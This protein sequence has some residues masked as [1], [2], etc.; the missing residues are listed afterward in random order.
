MGENNNNNSTAKTIVIVYA[1]ET[2]QAKII[3]ET[4]NDLAVENGFQPKLYNINQH[5]KEFNFN[6][7]TDP[8]VFICSTTGDG[9]TPETAR[10]CYFKLKRL[11]TET[12]KAYLSNLNY[13]LLGL[14]D[15][16]YTQF[17]NGPKL[18]HK[19]FEQLGAKC[20]YG[21]FWA[22]DGTGLELEVEP[23]KD[24]LWDALDEFYAKKNAPCP[25]I[26]H[27]LCLKTK[28]LIINDV[29]SEIQLT[30]PELVENHLAIEYEPSKDESFS[31]KELDLLKS[32]PHI[33]PQA[34]IGVFKCEVTQNS[35]MTSLDPEKDL[36]DFK[37]KY[38]LKFRLTDSF[39]GNEMKKAEFSY[40][41]GHAIDIVCPNSKDEVNKLLKRLK[42]ESPDQLI[43]IK[44]LDPAKKLG[45]SFVKLTE[46]HSISVEFLFTYCVDLRVNCLKKNFLRM[47]SFYCSDKL[48]Q[49]RLLELCSKEGSE[50]YLEIVKG[51]ALT[52]LD[53]LNTF[54][55][56]HPPLAHLIQ[57]LPLQTARS[58]TL[59]SYLNES[60]DIFKHEMEIV[61][62]MVTFEKNEYRT[63]KRNG[64]GTDYL[65]KIGVKESVYFLKR[66]FHNFTFPTGAESKKPIIMIG[67]GTGLAP[68]I[69]YLRHAKHQFD[70]KINTDPVEKWLFYGCRN[71][72]KDF[73]FKEE[74]FNDFLPFLT[75]F[76][77]AYSKFHLN[78][79]NGYK[80]DWYVSE[81]HHLK[82]SKYVQDII[83]HHSQELVRLINEKEG[84]IYLCGDA[85]N[86]SKD[87]MNCFVECLSKELSITAE[88]ANKY[89]MN[90]IKNKR[91]KQD[92]WA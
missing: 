28:N 27:Q 9:E 14:G 38:N 72:N 36:N 56:C 22:D 87:V 10:K 51:N 40:E 20:F 2:G 88:E 54:D 33:F 76:K 24:G 74:I 89:I 70:A 64:V 75:E 57:M 19:R 29:N 65:S 23:F 44:T 52:L 17:C 58:Y 50:H 15:T 86:M 13:A 43:K 31:S 73:L 45:S 26:E 82:E 61:F 18:F 62:N 39:V 37:Y 55:S 53:I 47:L 69:S 1:S 25:E 67:P 59:C 78:Q 41:P 34:A 77:V 92:I 63:Y 30:L 85:Q 60:D 68:F 16:N 84:Y 8:V 83:S 66:K 42:I 6:E 4:I 91:Y 49:V 48:D 11:D 21:P 32:F 71:P 35:P 80:N 46:Y 7:L 90:L 81:K 5:D 3:A 12:N 79:A